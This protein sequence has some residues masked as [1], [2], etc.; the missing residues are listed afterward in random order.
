MAHKNISILGSAIVPF[1][2]VFIMWLLFSI[3][4]YFH[5]EISKFGII[6][7]Q[8]WGLP[9]I[10]LA[11]FFHVNIIHIL[12]NTFPF[13]ILSAMLFYFYDSIA[14]A[15][16][17]RCYIFTNILV[18]CFAREL[19]HIGASGLIYAIASFLI[20]FG[21]FRKD[22]FSFLVSLVVLALY[23]SLASGLIPNNPFISFESHIIGALVG[24][25]TAYEF[26]KIHRLSK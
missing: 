7:R 26:R 10:I 18:W 9:G 21:F 20:F 11:P 19:N 24:L 22:R 4:F 16:F 15:V 23:G 25:F 14:K 12:S 17:F 6:P 8:L 2:M 1:R 5:V 3:E 13:V